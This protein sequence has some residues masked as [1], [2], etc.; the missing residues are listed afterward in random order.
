M[1]K[2]SS[3]VQPLGLAAILALGLGFAIWIVVVWCIQIAENMK[4]QKKEKEKIAVLYDGTPVITVDQPYQEVVYRDLEH[5]TIFPKTMLTNVK[6]E[7][8]TLAGP[9][10]LDPP[11]FILVSGRFP[12]DSGDRIQPFSES[13]HSRTYWYF[14]DD[15]NLAGRG[16]FMAF[17]RE[18]SA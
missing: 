17:D 15:G 3:I 7:H 5:K 6:L 4:T 13:R 18:S 8:V 14:I 10:D 16:Y 1:L 12:L 11:R 2:R 9:E